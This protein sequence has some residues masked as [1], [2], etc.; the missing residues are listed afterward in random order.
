[1]KMEQLGCLNIEGENDKQYKSI[2]LDVLSEFDPQPEIIDALILALN[3][4]ERQVKESAL[5]GIFRFGKSA[6]SALPKLKEMVSE[7]ENS[8][9]GGIIWDAIEEVEGQPPGF[10]WSSHPYD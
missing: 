8:R 10:P 3:D 6:A 5:R 9:T 7:E 4:T 1:M 2:C